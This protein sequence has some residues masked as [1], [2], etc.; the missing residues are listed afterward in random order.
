[1]K[2][3]TE[4]L[5]NTKVYHLRPLIYMLYIYE[6]KHYLDLGSRLIFNRR[7]KVGLYQGR[8][9][10]NGTEWQYASNVGY[11]GNKYTASNN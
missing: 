5:V 9:I 1:M 7:C 2:A 3:L 10:K 11:N 8:Q 6:P 4:A